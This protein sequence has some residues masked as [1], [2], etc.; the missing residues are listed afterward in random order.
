MSNICI[1]LPMGL[2]A[3]LALLLGLIGLPLASK[4]EEARSFSVGVAKVDI[5]PDYPVRLSGFGFRRTESE[6]VT[7]GIWAK[8]LALDDTEGA[9]DS[10]AAG[11]AVLITVDNL[12][13]PNSLVEELAGRLKKA[14]VVRQ[15]LAVTATHTH[16]APMLTGVAPTLYGMPI[17]PEHQARIDRYTREL[18]DKLEQVALAA[19]ADRQRAILTW[20]IGKVTFAKNRR[21]REGP[22]GPVDH[23]LPVLV[24]RS[25]AGKVRAIYTSYACHCVTLSNNRISGDWAG[26][27]QEA[28][29][30]A[31][32]GAVAL[33]SIGCG[34]DSNPTSGV[35]GDKVDIAAAQGAEI[36]AEVKRLV[37]RK[38]TPLERPLSTRLE[39]IDLPLEPRTREDW[40]ARSKQ[41][42][43]I[44]YHAQ[45]NLARSTAA[46][47]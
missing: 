23:D 32:P 35:T 12:G 3:A 29:E 15:R 14:G 41:A 11:P 34:A 21:T 8:A 30:R 26:Y 6:G 18:A 47:A 22:P 44:G 42:G 31:F 2:S 1:A 20:G 43:A 28:I 9:A 39:R 5:T 27:A 33:V 25:A 46:S 36:A 19:L 4:A 38:L 16:T 40:E 13:V 37:A 10:G 24:V 7:Q 17:S 45:V